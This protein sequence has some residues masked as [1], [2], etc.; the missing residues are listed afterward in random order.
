M[1]KYFVKVKGFHD[2]GLW[3]ETMVCNAVNRWITE[4]EFKRITG[5]EYIRE[6]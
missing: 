1:S 5:K 4:E 2:S 6:R 3:S